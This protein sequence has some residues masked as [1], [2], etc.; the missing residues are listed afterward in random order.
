MKKKNKFFIYLVL[1][2]ICLMI[3][4]PTYG[5]FINSLK[6]LKDLST[7]KWGLPNEWEFSNYTRVWTG[8]TRDVELVNIK[9]VGLSRYFYNSFRIAIPTVIMV[10]ILSLFLAFPLARFKIRFNNT[11]LAI[12]LFG[13][14]IPHQIMFI[15]IFK[16]L[17]ILYLYDTIWGLI[18]V[19]VGIG[20]PFTTFLFRNYMVQIPMGIQEAAYID[21]ATFWQIFY[22]IIVPLCRPAIAI[23]A[24]IQFQHVFNEFFYALILTNSQNVN[25]LTVGVALFSSSTEA[26]EWQL[27]ATAAMIL[28]MPTL[29]LFIAFQKFIVKGLTMGSVKG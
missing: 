24:I 18:I 15:P 17:D 22:K 5:L 13:I 11:I 7:N 14:A 16:A 27:Q 20:I 8:N 29:I 9:P 4:I 12:V 21:G 26:A 10:L 3:L 2:I 25:P 1:I 19:Y 23:M 6:S 28:S